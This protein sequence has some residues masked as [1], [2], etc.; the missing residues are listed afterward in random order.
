M[1]AIFK[2]AL[3]TAALYALPIHGFA[4]SLPMRSAR[5]SSHTALDHHAIIEIALLKQDW[6]QDTFDTSMQVTIDTS[7]QVTRATSI[8]SAACA[9]VACCILALQHMT[10]TKIS[11]T[12]NESIKMASKRCCVHALHAVRRNRR[13]MKVGSYFITTPPWPA[14][15]HRASAESQASNCQ[16]DLP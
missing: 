5:R 6:W 13:K 3:V 16:A 14:I 11:F 4:P 8:T 1:L 15:H 10:S 2:I 9:S 12:D 7:V